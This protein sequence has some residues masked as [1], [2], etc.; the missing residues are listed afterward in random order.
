[1]DEAGKAEE[2]GEDAEEKEENLEEGQ[3][4]RE[5]LLEIAREGKVTPSST[6]VSS[7]GDDVFAS[8]PSSFSLRVQFLC[9]ATSERSPPLPAQSVPSRGHFRR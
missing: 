9:P 3:T 7:E 5:K 1:M 6:N 2:D 8:C 4:Q